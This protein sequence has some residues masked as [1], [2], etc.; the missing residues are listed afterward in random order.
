[1]SYEEKIRENII[2]EMADV[3][4]MLD[5]LKHT[6]KISCDEINNVKL[7]K[8]NRTLERMKTGKES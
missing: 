5:R 2:E 7:R 6:L 4:V 1:M 8:V 3:G